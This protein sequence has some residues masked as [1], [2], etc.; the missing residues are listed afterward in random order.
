M[1]NLD[2]MLTH[3]VLEFLVNIY[4]FLMDLTASL[5]QASLD[6]VVISSNKAPHQIQITLKLF[7]DDFVLKILLFHFTR[8]YIEIVVRCVGTNCFTMSIPQ[9][10]N[11]SY[12]LL[13]IENSPGE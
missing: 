10:F 8:V 2:S 13:Y 9:V 12:K 11:G 1:S 5:T 3:E 6:T 7:T 4:L